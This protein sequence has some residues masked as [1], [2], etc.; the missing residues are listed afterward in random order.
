[1]FGLPDRLNAWELLLRVFRE[2]H[3]AATL[4]QSPLR[5][6]DVMVF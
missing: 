4:F 2:M 3:E 5:D 6:S 1:M